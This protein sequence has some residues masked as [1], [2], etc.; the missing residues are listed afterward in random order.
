M[1]YLVCCS[2]VRGCGG[3]G[4]ETGRGSVKGVRTGP[5]GAAV[6]TGVEVCPFILAVYR[7]KTWNF[8][9]SLGSCSACGKSPQESSLSLG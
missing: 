5:E 3:D 2:G 1:S 9:A 6:G 4:L 8:E 7:R